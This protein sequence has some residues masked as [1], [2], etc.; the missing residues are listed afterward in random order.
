MVRKL[1]YYLSLILIL[2]LSWGCAT[3]GIHLQRENNKKLRQYVE[4]KNF[5]NAKELVKSEKYYPEE[6]SRLVKILNTASLAYLDKNYAAAL[7]FYRQALSLSDE[8]YT[9]SIK[10]KATTLVSNDNQDLYYGENYERSYMRFYVALCYYHLYALEKDDKQAQQFLRNAR[11]AILDWDSFLT[12]IQ[13]ELAG[14]PTYK[15]DLAAKLFGAVIHEE[16]G[17]TGDMQIARQLYKDAKDVLLK[18]YNSYPSFNQKWE[19]YIDDYKKLPELSSQKVNELYIGQTSEQQN[20]FEFIKKREN[21]LGKASSK[22]KVIFL[23]QKSLI[24]SKVAEKVK[25][26]LTVNF[27][28][29]VAA[30]GNKVLG[31]IPF[32]MALLNISK[33][34]QPEISFEYP[35]IPMAPHQAPAKIKIISGQ[36]GLELPIALIAPLSEVAG[37]ETQNA[38]IMNMSKAGTRLATKHLAIMA[39]LYATYQIA[40]KKGG[41]AATLALPAAMGSYALASKQISDSELADL[42]EWTLLPSTISLQNAELDPGSYQLEIDGQKIGSFEVSKSKKSQLIDIFI[43]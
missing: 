32:A 38:K 20:L 29:T 22:Q 6:R 17:S 15:N 1:S 43:P 25:F 26:P 23:V 12:T 41:I 39:S 11:A 19:K 5:D 10:A 16:I 21:A 28:M 8:L 18:Q 34:L 9:T 36:N 13:Y 3:K 40:A 27:A 2:S 24:S 14:R 4:S 37:Q 7:E 42:R 30:G 35:L 31:P 33:G